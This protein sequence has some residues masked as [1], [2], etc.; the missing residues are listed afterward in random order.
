MAGV[1]AGGEEVL[2]LDRIDTGPA[3]G[4]GERRWPEFGF[5]L[6]LGLGLGFDWRERCVRDGG[7]VYGHGETSGDW[8][9]RMLLA[10]GIGVVKVMVPVYPFL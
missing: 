10:S 3:R 4:D 6:G 1:A 9:W 5:G 7:S 8:E 2:N